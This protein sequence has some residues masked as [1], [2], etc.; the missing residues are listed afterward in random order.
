LKEEHRLSVF[1][2]RVLRGIFKPKKLGD[3]LW[4]KLHNDILHSLY[5]SLNIVGVIKS[6]MMRWARHVACMRE[7]R[8]VYGVLVGGGRIMFRWT[9]YLREI[10]IDEVN[11][12]WLAQDRVQWQAFVSTATN[13][14]VP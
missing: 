1:E 10:G 11:W 12:I 2:N 4:R 13:L 3:G 6:R 8:G 5:S 7:G 14:R 9:L